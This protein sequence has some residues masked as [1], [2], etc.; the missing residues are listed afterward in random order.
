MISTCQHGDLNKWPGH[1]DGCNGIFASNSFLWPRLQC[2]MNIYHGLTSTFP[3][4]MLHKTKCFF[5]KVRG[6]GSTNCLKLI[7]LN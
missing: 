5:S 1:K 3:N 4:L 2:S 6:K 7:K